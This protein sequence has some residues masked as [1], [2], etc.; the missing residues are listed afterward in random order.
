M[1]LPL[2][3]ALCGANNDAKLTH[4]LPMTKYELDL[5]SIGQM[6]LTT[7]KSAPSEVA[8]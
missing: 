3:C 4:K 6:D 7:V 1:A 5:E 2:H 8:L